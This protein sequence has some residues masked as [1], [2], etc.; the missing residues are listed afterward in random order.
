VLN[1]FERAGG[2]CDPAAGR[3]RTRLQAAQV[4]LS[5]LRRWAPLQA[6]RRP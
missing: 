4:N 3:H 6:E 2:G 1:G 5:N